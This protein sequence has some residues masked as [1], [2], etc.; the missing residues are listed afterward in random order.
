[1]KGDNMENLEAIKITSENV[2]SAIRASINLAENA[3]K[4][5]GECPAVMVGSN[6]KE[7]GAVDARE[8]DMFQISGIMK[9][10]GRDE[11]LQAIIDDMLT[12]Y[13]MVV[14]IS[15][16]WHVEISAKTEQ[17]AEAI[18]E[19]I[20][21]TPINEHPDR[22]ECI[23]VRVITEQ[24]EVVAHCPIDRADNTVKH[25]SLEILRRGKHESMTRASI[26]VGP[27]SA[28]H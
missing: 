19:F 8:C 26:H 15:E 9:L 28:K 3:L 11:I 2:A 10:S 7:S 21:D 14:M 16:A 6:L 17:Q 23:F 24:I 18:A 12:R 25:A 22:Q 13:V 27:G 4:L 1:M 20:K 5:S